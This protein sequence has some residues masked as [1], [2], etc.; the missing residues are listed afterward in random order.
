MRLSS[1]LGLMLRSRQLHGR[2]ACLER[3]AASALFPRLAPGLGRG[4]GHDVLARRF[5][6]SGV[7]SG[8]EGDHER[9]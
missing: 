2:P 7:A 5:E 6:A 8:G 3:K 1:E 9:P 4:D